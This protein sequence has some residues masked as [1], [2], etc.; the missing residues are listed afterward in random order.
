VAAL[1]ALVVDDAEGARSLVTSALRAGGFAVT[2]AVDGAQARRAVTACRP[3][4]AVVELELTDESGLDLLSQVFL[5][6]G[7]PAVIL[8]ARAGP[9]ERVVGLELG[10][11]DY[12]TK[13]FF[14]SELAARVRRAA[15]RRPAA[16][17]LLMVGDLMV[18]VATREATVA[19]R[20]VDL[21]AREFDL[22]AHL[23]TAPR[24]AFS[25]EE[26]LRH[27]WRSSSEWQSPRTVTEHVRRLR[28][29]VEDEPSRPRRIVTVAGGRY[30]LE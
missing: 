13:P 18:D 8:S 11:E 20:Q 27:V 25:R 28:A 1:T 29:K 10:A 15:H 21:T 12:V 9:A 14:P 17:S 7:I 3:D 6:A 16:S 5:P 22:L 26:L 30:R 24:R 23:A 4:V 19:G 2:E